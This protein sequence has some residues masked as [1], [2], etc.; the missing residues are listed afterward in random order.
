MLGYT[1]LSLSTYVDKSGPIRSTIHY[2]LTHLA[3]SRFYMKLSKD[4]AQFQETVLYILL[5][6]RAASCLHGQGDEELEASSLFVTCF[7]VW[8]SISDEPSSLVPLGNQV[9]FSTACYHTPLELVYRMYT[10]SG[11]K[12]VLK[13]YTE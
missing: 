4:L 3:A 5:R 12:V 7:F 9:Y 11:Y 13:G 1:L 10:W 8:L 6:A 2:P